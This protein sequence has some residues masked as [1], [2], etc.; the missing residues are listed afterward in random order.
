MKRTAEFETNVPTVFQSSVSR[1]RLLI[2]CPPAMNRWATFDRPLYADSNYSLCKTAAL[3]AGVLTEQRFGMFSCLCVNV[4][5]D[6][7]SHLSW[8]SHAL[9]LNLSRY[10]SKPRCDGE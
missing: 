10:C 9:L 5:R 4:R 2:S 6:F 1:T 3:D 8:S 7:S